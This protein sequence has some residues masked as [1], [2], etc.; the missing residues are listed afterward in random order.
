MSARVCFGLLLTFALQLHHGLVPLVL[1]R[2]VLRGDGETL[3]PGVEHDHVLVL[4]VGPLVDVE[5]GLQ[6]H[7]F[8]R[9]GGLA[10][11]FLLALVVLQAGRAALRSGAE[12]KVAPVHGLLFA[13][14]AA[15][16]HV[17]VALVLN[18]LTLHV[19]QCLLYF[20]QLIFPFL[21][22]CKFSEVIQTSPGSSPL[23][24]INA[25]M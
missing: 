16:P 2:L 25:G 21:W 3:G 13:E 24:H 22:I 10:A 5:A 18:R 7:G 19:T 14:V 8:L 4:G 23:S 6:R 1:V 12:H 17:L 11:E 20:S 9:D 15:L